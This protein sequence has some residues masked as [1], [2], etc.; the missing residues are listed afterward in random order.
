MVAGVRF[1][2][3]TVR[4]AATLASLTGSCRRHDVDPQLYFMLLLVN[5]PAWRESDLDA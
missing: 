1:E 4:T 3:T 5:L 2:L